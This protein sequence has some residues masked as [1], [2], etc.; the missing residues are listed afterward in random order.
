MHK[1]CYHKSTGL[2]A[3][4]SCQQEVLAPDKW[5]SATAVSM[6]PEKTFH[7]AVQAV[8]DQ[9]SVPDKKRINH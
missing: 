2:L 6:H 8:K 1:L 9:E 4:V 5:R 7:L 3:S